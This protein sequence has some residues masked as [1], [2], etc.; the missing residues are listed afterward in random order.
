MNS[1]I[2]KNHLLCFLSSLKINSMVMIDDCDYA[3][4]DFKIYFTS[5][6]IFMMLKTRF[7]VMMDISSTDVDYSVDKP[8]SRSRSRS[9]YRNISRS[10]SPN[11]VSPVRSYSRSVDSRY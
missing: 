4:I 1:E 8:P 6:K 10:L 5:L 7:T 2:F 9:K 3:S 11:Q